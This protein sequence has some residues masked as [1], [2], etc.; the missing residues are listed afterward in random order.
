MI[1]MILWLTHFKNRFITPKSMVFTGK[2]KKFQKKSKKCYYLFDK[3]QKYQKR[4]LTLQKKC[5]IIE[6]RS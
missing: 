5:N 2:S 1:I 3:P 6:S 4:V